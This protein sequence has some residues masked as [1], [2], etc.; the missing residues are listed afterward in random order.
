VRASLRPIQL[1]YLKLWWWGRW[2]RWGRASGPSNSYTWSSDGEEDGPGEGEPQAHPTPIPEALMVRKMVPVRA[3]LRPIQLLYLKLW[4]WGRW[5]WWG[6]ASGSSTRMGR[7]AGSSAL[8]TPLAAALHTH[9]ALAFRAL[10]VGTRERENQCS[11]LKTY[12][13]LARS[14]LRN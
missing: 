7:R 3:S 10:L 12:Y 8:P 9:R 2:S 6:R 1:L 5:S 11:H 4:W 13:L 14:K